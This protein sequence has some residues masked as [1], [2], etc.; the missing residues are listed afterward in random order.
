VGRKPK[1]SF[2]L[3]PTASETGSGLL[4]AD[5]TLP[6]SLAQLANNFSRRILH[7]DRVVQPKK[8]VKTASTSFWERSHDTLQ[9]SFDD[10]ATWPREYD[11]LLDAGFGWSYPCLIR[12]DAGHIG[13]VYAG[14]QA[15]IQFQILPFNE[16]LHR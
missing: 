13:I 15:Q 4:E 6:G 11:L 3:A 9:V 12:I 16:I 14:S 5:E 2:R 7:R 8:G 10:G 1:D